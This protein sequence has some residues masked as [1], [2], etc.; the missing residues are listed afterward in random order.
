[1]GFVRPQKAVKVFKGDNMEQDLNKFL[2]E[3]YN[4]DVL[5][6]SPSDGIIVLEYLVPFGQHPG[7]GR[8]E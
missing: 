2:S 1:M 4:S 5:N 3:L 7:G 8:P 6:I